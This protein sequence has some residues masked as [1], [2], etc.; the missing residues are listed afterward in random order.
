VRE[1]ISGLTVQNRDFAV[2]LAN[3]PDGIR[4][5]GHIKENNLK[6]V[7]VKWNEL[8]TRWRSPQAGTTQHAA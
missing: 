6:G 4:G 7:R 1:L 3:L 2:E 5:F 8:L